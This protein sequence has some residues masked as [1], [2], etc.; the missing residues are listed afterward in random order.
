MPLIGDE[1]YAQADVQ[2]EGW[3]VISGGAPKV[4]EFLHGIASQ[5]PDGTFGV[6]KLFG[7]AYF[8]FIFKE[9]LS[10]RL[11]D[12]MV[13]VSAELGLHGRNIARDPATGQERLSVAEVAAEI[14]CSDETAAHLARLANAF[15]PHIGRKGVPRVVHRD[16]V[17]MLRDTFQAALSRS[18]TAARLGIATADF[19]DLVLHGHLQKLGTR[20]DDMEDRF[21]VTEV[22]EFLDRIPLR[23]P[24]DLI[25]GVEVAWGRTC[26]RSRN[27]W[28][29]RGTRPESCSTRSSPGGSSHTPGRASPAGSGHSG[30]TSA[31]CRSAMASPNDASRPPRR[32]ATETTSRACRRRRPVRSWT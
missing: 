1:G 13:E 29:Q 11:K 12:I 27:C 19:A 20:W 28:P 16:K 30:S 6:G 9:H 17:E 8:R 14:G 7:W 21:L 2:R 18:D 10:F 22:D 31:T 25:P 5:A 26:A 15:E 3:D 32:A 23:S 4:R 24:K